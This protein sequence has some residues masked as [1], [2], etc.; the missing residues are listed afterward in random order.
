M[1]G[2][3]GGPGEMFGQDGMENDALPESVG[4]QGLQ[5]DGQQAENTKMQDTTNPAPIPEDAGGRPAEGVLNE[6]GQNRL[7]ENPQ[8]QETLKQENLINK[9]KNN[10]ENQQF[11]KN[12]FAGAPINGRKQNQQSAWE[13]YV[14]LG[15]SVVALLLGILFAALYRKRR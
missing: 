8:Q 11:S 9:E 6:Q 2:M 7:R 1:G 13:Q 14:G 12:N 5:S 10:A 3:G 15:I 4:E